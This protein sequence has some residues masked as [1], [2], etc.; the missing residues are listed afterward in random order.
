MKWI[1]IH[2]HRLSALVAVLLVI[3]F[4]TS[5]AAQGLPKISIGIEES[6][7]P[8]DLSVTLK[9]ILL[10]TVLSL[11]PS[12]VITMTSF[13]R[14][15]VVLS[16]L[17]HAL[18]TQQMPPAQLLVGLAL[19]LSFFIMAP[20]FTQSYE[21]GI[22]PYTEGTID[23][24]QAFELSMA[25]V[26]EFM[27]KQTR[28]KDLALFVRLAGLEKPA[29]AADVPLRA[30]LPGFVISELR[31]AFQIG[32]VL[33]IP[34]L[35]IDMVVASV[36]MSMGMLMLPPIMVAMPFKILLFVLVD[37]WYLVVQSLVSSFY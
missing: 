17:K 27:L 37:G 31:V 10:L 11:A 24:D 6:D 22:K 4:A 1:H 30:L 28:E 15:I 26:R 16:F 21:Q 14:I 8:A 25:P 20:V 23:R 36:L 7:N 18:G 32:F 34:F 35:I 3:V 13:T 29:T 5:A 19:I 2:R 9:I 33:F 12:I